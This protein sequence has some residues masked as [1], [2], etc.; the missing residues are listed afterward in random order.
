MGEDRPVL[1]DERRPQLAVSAHPDRALHV[2]LHGV[3]DVS[4]ADLAVESLVDGV[5]HQYLWTAREHD[6]S[7]GINS[8]SAEQLRDH[9][10]AAV[11]GRV[12]QST[13]IMTSI[14]CR[15]HSGYSAVYRRSAGCRAP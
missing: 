3:E 4:V 9:A 14:P 13:V 7:L 11:P 8:K 6:G 15:S 5:P 2:S 1:A 10:Y 12:A